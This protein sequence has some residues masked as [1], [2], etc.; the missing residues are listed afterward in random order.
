MSQSKS[1]PPAWVTALLD[2]A[3]TPLERVLL[4]VL[5]RYQGGKDYAWPTH[6]RLAA[7]LG[8]TER[9]VQRLVARLAAKGRLTV[10]R[11]ARQGRG[12]PNHYVVW[13]EPKG[14]QKDDTGDPLYSG[15]KDDT[16]RPKRATS[17]ANLRGC[18]R[19]NKSRKESVGAHTPFS[20]PAVEE[21]RAYAE[22]IGYEALDAERFA[23]HYRSNGWRVGQA[24]MRDWQAAVRNWQRRDAQSGGKG[25]EPEDA[26]DPSEEE[27]RR[28]LGWSDGA[29][30][31]AP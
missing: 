17:H 21:V 28:L 31:G 6:P 14:R 18:I 29:E 7:D 1:S 9:T 25:A 26:H 10:E 13:R 4:A 15:E 20:P 8:T 30:G 23:D 12:M 16:A 11:P 22:S 24:P 2:N 27:A 19:K 3:L 5:A